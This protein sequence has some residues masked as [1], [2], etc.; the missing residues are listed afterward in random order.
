MDLILSLQGFLRALCLIVGVQNY[1]SETFSRAL[2]QG[3]PRKLSCR[4]TIP[5]GY[6]FLYLP[7]GLVVRKTAS[8]EL[9][10]FLNNR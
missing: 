4:L 8:F 10:E 1:L 3:E 7:F 5:R 9:L 2:Y 6:N